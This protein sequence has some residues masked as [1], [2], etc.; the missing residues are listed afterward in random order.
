MGGEELNMPRGFLPIAGPLRLYRIKRLNPASP[1]F[2]W[3][4]QVFLGIPSIFLTII[5]FTTGRAGG[6]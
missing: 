4:V 6:A 5:L 1:V 2:F 3:L